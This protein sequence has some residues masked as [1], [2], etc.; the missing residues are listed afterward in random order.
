MGAIA[1]HNSGETEEVKGC[2][3]VCFSKVVIY[4]RKTVNLSFAIHTDV[5]GFEKQEEE[6]LSC[7]HNNFFKLVR[8]SI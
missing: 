3:R 8:L 6:E 1:Y 7:T 4:L 5:F 2:L